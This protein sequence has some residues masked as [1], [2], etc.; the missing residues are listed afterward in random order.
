[1]DEAAVARVKSVS[2]NYMDMENECCTHI[3]VVKGTTLEF[4]IEAA[5]YYGIEASIQM[6]S[7]PEKRGCNL[8]PRD[9]KGTNL[10]GF[11]YSRYDMWADS[12]TKNKEAC[13]YLTF[14][15]LPSSGSE[16][17]DLSGDLP[18]QVFSSKTESKLQP[19][20]IKEGAQ[21][22]LGDLTLTVGSPSQPFLP[23]EDK[24]SRVLFEF[25]SPN[26]AMKIINMDFFDRDGKPLLDDKG[27]P[28]FSRNGGGRSISM[29]YTSEDKEYAFTKK[30]DLLNISVQYWEKVEE[31][32]LPVPAKV[33]F[34]DPEEEKAEKGQ[35]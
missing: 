11:K 22:F 19:L 27:E 25:R 15:N 18:V 5:E 28:A 32:D 6:M 26:K 2:F 13:Y 1:M 10:G 20:Q 4:V 24:Q 30:P 29:D 12:N 21:L 8:S 33:L 23:Q 31:V 7:A 34:Y 3:W 16:G 9:A 35:Q 17:L 14:S